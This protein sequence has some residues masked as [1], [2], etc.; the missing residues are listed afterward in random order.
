MTIEVK[1]IIVRTTVGE[2]NK[3]LPFNQFN[4]K[5]LKLEILNELKKEQRKIEKHRKER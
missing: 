2:G 5:K 3:Y 4:I 1:E